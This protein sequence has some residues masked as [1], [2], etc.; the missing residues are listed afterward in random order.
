MNY[1]WLSLTTLLLLSSSTAAYDC[2]NDRCYDNNYSSWV[3]C[4]QQYGS[5]NVTSSGRAICDLGSPGWGVYCDCSIYRCYNEEM[6]GEA[7]CLC[8]KKSDLSISILVGVIISLGIM[9]MF[10][11]FSF[12][13]MKLVRDRG[14]GDVVVTNE[15]A[16]DQDVVIRERY[17]DTVPERYL[18]IVPPLY[19]EQEQR[20]T[21]QPPSYNDAIKVTPAERTP[22][23]VTSS[24]NISSSILLPSTSSSETQPTDSCDMPPSYSE[25]SND[26]GI[27][28]NNDISVNN[29]GIIVACNDVTIH[30]NET[31]D[32][33]Q[34]QR[35]RTQTF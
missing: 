6:T 11:C 16:V 23:L 12:R 27:T 2:Y 33:G 10:V 8:M 17:H 19:S 18:D 21:E 4:D 34:E 13:L 14:F 24:G 3:K 29:H 35:L 9:L 31:A 1:Q 20:P 32:D 5:C 22:S 7:Q 15:E 26:H 25:T 30:T 28:L